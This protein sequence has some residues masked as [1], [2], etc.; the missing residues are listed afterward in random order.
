MNQRIDKDQTL[1]YELCICS[2]TEDRVGRFYCRAIHA[3]VHTPYAICRSCPL[4][5][6]DAEGRPACRYYDING[7]QNPE[8]LSPEERRSRIDGLIAAGLT[9]EFPEFFPKGTPEKNLVIERAIRFAAEAHKGAVRKGNGYPYIIHP[10]ETMGIVSEITD[11]PDVIAAAALHDVLEDTQTTPEELSARFGEKITHLVLMESEDK[12]SG[13][14]KNQTWKIRK[15]E[16]LRRELSAPLDAKKIMLA[17]KIS[18]LRATLEDYRISGDSVWEKFNMRDRNE[19]EW[20]YR[21]VA[22]VLSDLSDT[23]QYQE[24]TKILDEVFGHGESQ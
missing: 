2:R 7:D 22:N 15:T 9:G 10:V 21:S 14:P 8:E 3:V 18:N 11:D 4:A 23:P 20:Y 19:Q 13:R 12:R 17:D 24:Y 5:A 1:C 16:N 6:T